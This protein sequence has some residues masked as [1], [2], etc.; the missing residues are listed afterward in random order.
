MFPK[1]SVPSEA[2]SK[3]YIES[4]HAFLRDL[5]PRLPATSAAAGFLVPELGS[6][7]ERLR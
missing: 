6:A 5:A 1:M 3:S 7:I 2:W 4:D